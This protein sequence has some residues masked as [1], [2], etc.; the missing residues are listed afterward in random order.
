[1]PSS[2]EAAGE[3][4]DSFT[5]HCVCGTVVY[6]LGRHPLKVEKGVRLPS[7]LLPKAADES[8]LSASPLLFLF[9]HGSIHSQ[10]WQVSNRLS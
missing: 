10:A 4:F 1:L 3:R 9:A 6:W 5:T 7:V 2:C 8:Q